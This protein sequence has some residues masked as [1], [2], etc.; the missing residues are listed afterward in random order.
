MTTEQEELFENFFNRFTEF[1]SGKKLSPREA[2]R[3]KM[4]IDARIV[5]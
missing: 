2:E 5:R 3:M 4:V 1:M